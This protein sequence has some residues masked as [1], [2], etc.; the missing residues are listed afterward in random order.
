VCDWIE[1]RADLDA[2]KIA[3]WGVSLGGYSRRARPHTRGASA[4][5]SALSGP[6]EWKEIWGRCRC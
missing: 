1:K 6:F 4:P 2:A 5:A 3:M